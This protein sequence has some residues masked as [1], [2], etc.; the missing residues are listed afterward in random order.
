[1]N[2]TATFELD[3]NR[4]REDANYSLPATLECYEL[5]ELSASQMAKWLRK[6]DQNTSATL[7]SKGA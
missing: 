5:K 2:G 6:T 4:K 1:M 3:R 7:A